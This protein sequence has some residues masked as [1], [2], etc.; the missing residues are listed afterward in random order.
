MNIKPKVSVIVPVYNQEKYIGRCLRSLLDQSLIRGMYEIIVINDGS[1][2]KTAYALEIFE[3]EIIILSN[4]KNKGLSFSVN[5]GIKSAKGRF[6]I[7]VDSDDYVNK[8]FL[9][10]MSIFLSLNSSFDAVC[11]DYHLVND[12]EIILSRENGINKPIACGIMFK[13]KQLMDLG[14]YDS[15]F[16]VHEDKDLRYRF[17][18]K[19]TIERLP[20]PL[21]RYRKHSSNITDNNKIMKK[22][23]K[24]LKRKHKIK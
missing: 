12:K 1:T 3:D 18:Q 8:E 11:C 17:L 2:D 5:K 20:L 7:R 24:R 10:F 4:K 13:T 6:V 9:N 16:T 14:L 22:D 19:H 23:F 15:L 21:Y